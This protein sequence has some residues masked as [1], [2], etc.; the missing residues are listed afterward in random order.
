[1]TK[2]FK[3]LNNTKFFVSKLFH[4]VNAILKSHPS[5]ITRL[6]ENQSS[7][8]PYGVY[9]IWLKHLNGLFAPVFVNDS[10]PFH[11]SEE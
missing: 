2:Q 3:N 7:V 10:F 6:F 5:I 4:L 11:S 9:C 1:M 8:N